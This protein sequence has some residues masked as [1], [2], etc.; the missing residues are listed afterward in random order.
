MSYI[1]P[2]KLSDVEIQ[3]L[4]DSVS[5]KNG[6]S[7][8]NILVEQWIEFGKPLV[9]RI[10]IDFDDGVEMITAF[11]RTE[12][13]EGLSNYVQM[14]IDSAETF[15]LLLNVEDHDQHDFVLSN[16]YRVCN[17]LSDEE[18]DN[19]LVESADLIKQSV[20]F[21][22][23]LKSRKEALDE[24]DQQYD[25]GF[26]ARVR[27]TIGPYSQN[28]YNQFIQDSYGYTGDGMR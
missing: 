21:R 27:E 20:A 17:G 8:C 12:G 2:N 25:P 1:A 23:S 24:E 9:K 5:S 19:L 15:N 6:E 7:V 3:D 28:L 18:V 13:A 22:E 4:L 14:Y 11:T 10:T 16:A 26:D